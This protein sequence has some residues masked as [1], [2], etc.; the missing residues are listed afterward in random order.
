MVDHR[1]ILA[2]VSINPI[3]GII[4]PVAGR[5]IDEVV[6]EKDERHKR[7][8]NPMVGELVSIRSKYEKVSTI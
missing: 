3:L 1:M 5:R 4:P 8:I 7:V 6:P 2:E